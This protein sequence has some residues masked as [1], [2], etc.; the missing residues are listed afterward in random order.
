MTVA[1][2]VPAILGLAIGV[3][4]AKPDGAYEQGLEKLH[5]AHHNAVEQANRDFHRGHL[6]L[7]DKKKDQLDSLRSRAAD[8]KRFEEVSALTQEIKGLDDSIT[9][10]REFVRSSAEPSAKPDPGK[11]P[12][13]KTK[14]D[15][16]G[17]EGK[18]TD[19]PDPRLGYR[20][21]SRDGA[22]AGPR[23]YSGKVIS[24]DANEMK[25]D[26]GNGVAERWVMQHD[27]TIIIYSYKNGKLFEI[28]LMEV[29][30]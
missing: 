10:T 7:L 16:Y 3:C 25:A 15:W 29:D 22:I 8:A 6:E 21:V 26:F 27:G 24:A 14:A 20:K 5:K 1:V 4:Y 11:K 13:T 18:V 9:I 30:D 12:D 19:P 17:I 28:K 2:L 23:G